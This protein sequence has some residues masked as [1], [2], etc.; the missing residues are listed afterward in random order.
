M[1]AP[2]RKWSLHLR[3]DL[4]KTKSYGSSFQIIQRSKALFCWTFFPPM[5]CACCFCFVFCLVCLLCICDLCQEFQHNTPFGKSLQ[6]LKALSQWYSRVHRRI[7]RRE[8]QISQTLEKFMHRLLVFFLP[9]IH[10]D[11]FLSPAVKYIDLCG[12]SVQG[13]PFEWD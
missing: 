12:V 3:K 10:A 4:T 11:M 5:C 1:R 2:W 8:R 13:S 7:S 6:T 9:G